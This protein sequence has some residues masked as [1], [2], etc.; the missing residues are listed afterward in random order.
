MMQRMRHLILSLALIVPCATSAIAADAAG[1]KPLTVLAAA[2]LADAF[3]AIGA[4]FEQ[5]HPGLKVE[6]SFASSSTLATQ[7]GEG[8][9]ADV[10]AS[11][12]ESNMQKVAADLAAPARTFAANRLAIVV[13]KGNR[14]RIATLGDLAG[15]GVTVALAAPQVPAGR[16]AAEAFQKAGVAVVPA[17]QEVDVRA[18]L[19]KVAMDEADAGIV[20]V[21]DIRAA[22]DKVDAVAIPDEYNVTARY[23]IAVLKQSGTPETA[24]AFVNFVLSPAGQTT[25]KEFGFL[26][27]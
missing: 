23:P 27:P 8:A 24:T 12:D 11:A 7:I 19:T 10:F 14:K 6:F 5:A 26:A 18:V 17:S 13:P 25:L 16:Y 2:S 9:R 1:S 15:S 22:A 3:T 21:T 20:Y 4:A